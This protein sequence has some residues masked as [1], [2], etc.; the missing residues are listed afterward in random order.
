MSR[1]VPEKLPFFE[2]LKLSLSETFAWQRG[3]L[4]TGGALATAAAIVAVVVLNSSGPVGY[5]NPNMS[6][7]AVTV[8]SSDTAMK[9]QPVVMQTKSGD[10]IIW[11]VEEPAA[12]E[13]EKTDKPAVKKQT[14][15]EGEELGIDPV[16]PNEEKK[17]GEL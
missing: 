14:G 11:V 1:I 5:A 4:L 15:E 13:G 17:A 12:A 3:P 9:V 8:D 6:L 2:R 10:S 7:Q 16:K